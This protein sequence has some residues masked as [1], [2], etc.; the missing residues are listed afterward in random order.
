MFLVTSCIMILSEILWADSEIFTAFWSAFKWKAINIDRLLMSFMWKPKTSL[1]R[2]T[3]AAGAPLSSGL[4]GFADGQ[5]ASI[6][7]NSGCCPGG[8]KGQRHRRVLLLFV[9]LVIYSCAS[10]KVNHPLSH[11]VTLLSP[12]YQRAEWSWGLHVQSVIW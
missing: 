8:I 11:T 5:V 4:G 2:S 12:P 1:S 9:Q 10:H 3:S 6:Q 7:F